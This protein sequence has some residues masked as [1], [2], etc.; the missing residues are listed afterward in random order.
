MIGPARNQCL[1]NLSNANG[2]RSMSKRIFGL[3]VA[4]L[5]GSAALMAVHANDAHAAKAPVKCEL[6]YS[7][8]GW[9]AIYQHAHGRGKVT[10]DNGQ[11][12][13][14]TIQMHGG[15]LTAGKFHV[16]G[17]GDISNVYGVKDVF[18]SYAQA[19]ASAGVVQSGTAQVLTKGTVSIALSGTGEG[20][21]LGVAVD[22]FDIKPAH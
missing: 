1:I 4:V 7:L 6:S 8:S 20:I 22:K 11:H 19:G 21:D 9:S 17:K 10:C 2:D 15:G 12:A 5:I 14:V 16:T 13:N 18:G 3:S